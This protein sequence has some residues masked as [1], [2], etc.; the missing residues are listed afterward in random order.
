[1]VANCQIFVQGDQNSRFRPELA[2]EL[3]Q[4]DTD[5]EV[6]VKVNDVGIDPRKQIREFF[7][8][9]RRRLHEQE[10][11]EPGGEE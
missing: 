6:M 10:T 8:H 2:R 11:I 4:F 5:I 3:D 7:L 9:V 1:M